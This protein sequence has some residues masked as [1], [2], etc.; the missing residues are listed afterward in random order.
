[1]RLNISAMKHI[2]V[3]ADKYNCAGCGAC[4]VSCPKHCITMTMDNEG[5]RYPVVNENDCIDCGICL[6]KCPWQIDDKKNTNDHFSLPKV[7]AV[8]NN[9]EVR[10]NSTSG[11][12]FTAI[13]DYILSHDGWVCGAVFNEK[14]L[15]VEHVLSNSVEVRNRM[16]GSKY[17]QSNLKNVYKEIKQILE[18]DKYVLFTGTPCQTAGLISYL[19]KDYQKLFIVDILC[20]STPSPLIF[21]NIVSKGEGDVKNIIFRDKSLGWRGS[22]NFRIIKSNGTYINKTF[23]NLFFKGLINRP[24][25]YHCK[26]TNTY[27]RSDIT[28]GDYWNIKEIDDTFEDKLGV[29]CVLINTRKGLDLFEK[30]R[31]GMICISTALNPAIQVCMKRPVTE[32]S[33]RKAFWKDY[34]ENGIE[35]VEGKY[36]YYTLWETVKSNIIAPI[37]RKI[38][39]SDWLRKIRF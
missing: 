19:K 24:S 25:C 17:V 31:N 29:S 13:S 26:F 37:V 32:P 11:G 28:I 35:Y 36:G 22:Y 15:E 5:F 14:T 6:K 9:D 34:Y 1:M 33:K 30:I 4:L 39:I 20:H 27:R 2:N 3:L 23:L 10:I 18:E 7:F 16:R 38:G 8:K 21:K 12:I